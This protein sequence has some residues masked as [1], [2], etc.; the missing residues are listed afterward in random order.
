MAPEDQI[1][2]A[3]KHGETGGVAVVAYSSFRAVWR[4]NGWAEVSAENSTVEELKQ[5]VDLLGPDTTGL[6]DNPTKAELMALI[7]PDKG[8]VKFA[9]AAARGDA[10]EPEDVKKG[11]KS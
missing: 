1:F 8:E 7:A 5:A 10:A 11:G 2:I 6:S 4:H 9:E 3:M